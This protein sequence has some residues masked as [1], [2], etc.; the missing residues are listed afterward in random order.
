VAEVL[1]RY[2][3]ALESRNL[4]DLKRVW[5]SL[6]GTQQDAILREFRNANRISVDVV[7]P[8]IQGTSTGATV[9]FLRR[10]DLLTVDGQRL[11]SES[12]TVMEIRRTTG[13]WVIESIRYSQVR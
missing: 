12:H 13:S 2:K 1:A 11:H 9:S 3:S 7:D 6:G 10:Y 4:D 5:P 8:H